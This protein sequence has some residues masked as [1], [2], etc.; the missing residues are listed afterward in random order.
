MKQ[1]Q[2][3]MKHGNVS[4]RRRT[5]CVCAVAVSA[6]LLS[7]NAVASPAETAGEAN[8]AAVASDNAARI[9]VRGT[10]VDAANGDPLINAIVK[11][12]GTSNGVN[13]NIDGK[14]ALNVP[15]NAVI[16][17]SYVGYVTQTIDVNGRTDFDIQMKEDTQLLEEVVVVGYAAQKKVN[18]TGAV[19]SI[20][21]DE[22]KSSRPMT[23]MAAA[24][25]GMSAGLNVMQTGGKP[26]SEGQN[27]SIRGLGT[28]NNS[29]PLILVDG[30]E[31]GLNEI[32]PNDVASVSV[33]KDA[34]S[35]AIYG[36]R[37]A[38][39]VILVTTKRGNKDGRISVTYSGKFTL[40][41]P[42]KI[43]RQVSNYAD[44]MEMVNEAYYGNGQAEKFSATT[45]Q[46]WRDADANPNGVNEAGIPNYVSHPNTDWY[47]TLYKKQWMQEHTISLTGSE[48]RT[49]YML[50]GTFLNN[51]GIIVDAGGLKKYY[52]RTDILS[53]VTDFL[54]VGMRAW[55][56]HNDQRRDDLDNIFNNVSMQKSTPGV[57]PYYNG[58]YGG[59]ETTEEDGS[60]SN[61]L[62]NIAGEHGYYKQDKLYVN[63]YVELDLPLGIRF[64]S[65]FYYDDYRN[66]HKWN[67]SPFLQQVSFNRGIALN[68]DRTENNMKDEA[69]YNWDAYDRSWKTTNVLSFNN[70]FGK[71]EVGALAG[72]EEFR[73]W[74]GTRDLKKKG[75]TDINLTDFDSLS[76][77]DYIYGSNWEYSSRSWFGR[78]NYAYDSRYLLE[79]NMRYDG[80]SRFSKDHRWGFFPSFSAGWRLSEE[81]FMKDIDWLDNLKLRVSYGKLGN[82]SIGN[83]E[84]QA[85]YSP[86]A[87]VSF[88]DKLTS[89]LRMYKFANTLL[90]WESTKVTNVGVDFNFLN[91]RLWGT[92][93]VYN[94]NTDGI[95]YR[96]TLS[97]ML[98]NFT[99]PLQNLAEVNNKGLEM[100]LTWNDRVGDWAY[101]VSGNVTFNRNRVTKYKGAL[102]QEWQKD[103]EGNPVWVNNIGEISAGGTQRVLEGHEMNEYYM[104]NRYHGNGSYFNA[105]GSVNINGGPKDGMI[106]T[107]ADMKWLRA[108]VD[109]GYRFFPTQGIGKGQIW[110]GDY[111][112]ADE[113]GDGKYG[114]DQD[115]TFQGCSNM[116]KIYFG[117]QGSVSWKGID[118][119]M[120]WAGA[121]GFK[122]NYYQNTQNS[123][124][125]IHGY[126]IGKEVGYDHYYYDPE[127]PN[128]PR[129]N[130]NS[131]NPRFVTGADNGQQKADSEYHLQNGNY[132]K[133]KN[134][135][136]GWTV[137]RKWT[138]KAFMQNVRVY[139]SFENLCTITKF[140]GIDPEMMSGDGYAPMRSYAFGLNV[141]F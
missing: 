19:S 28:L 99:A 132:L 42:Q 106:R 46:E 35:C 117:L 76:T 48:K 13:S 63:P 5:G 135:T 95:L 89:G 26:N 34:A 9:T 54:A 100:T 130:I 43:I 102:V 40:N 64:T 81:S 90:S 50:S 53:H 20:D 97:S 119:S 110:Y 23:T 84:W 29:G 77:A 118:L 56:Y 123:T 83:Y 131:V 96:P 21:F 112:Y 65:N 45:I 124:N 7:G 121:A 72:Y 49:E 59:I 67:P 122:I 91:N 78:L 109:A 101:S 139:A 75:M 30:M 1:I 66:N 15:A 134:L 126:G 37:G 51:P 36:N 11:E 41:T 55:G 6:L 60:T 108:M 70:R 33:L 24:L 58:L 114:D 138:T 88:G 2:K 38:N 4:M 71:H 22:A 111:I 137:P 107:E 62:L 73:K 8:V 103:A 94:K 12:K 116:P 125:V 80:S 120:A 79:V 74:G 85:L 61:M 18:L 113:N 115:R 17:I 44:Y 31:A 3:A 127:N 27:I 57:Y 128:D 129:T 133:L 136:V 93:D 69:V 39:G 87:K 14:F 16:E 68:F 25:S 10:I 104:I 105:D 98:A 92:V 32:N 141:T 52:L 140:K 82:N 86:D 47:D